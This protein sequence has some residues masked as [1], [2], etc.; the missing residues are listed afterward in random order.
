MMRGSIL[1]LVAS[2]LII[3]L[4]LFAQVAVGAQL[5]TVQQVAVR[6]QPPRQSLGILVESPGK[7]ISV[8]QQ[9]DIV[10]VVEIKT[11]KTLFKED[12]WLKITHAGAQGDSLGGWVYYGTASQSE[13]FKK[14]Q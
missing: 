13:N 1:F 7:Q 2:F 4:S 8:L 12:V 5:K 10:N 14:A 6:E 11:V 9:G 3:P